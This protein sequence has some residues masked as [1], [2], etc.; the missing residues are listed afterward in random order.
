MNKSNKKYFI[1]WL[2][3]NIELKYYEFVKL[4]L[5]DLVRYVDIVFKIYLVDMLLFK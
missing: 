1:L 3:K 4:L 2:K 5:I